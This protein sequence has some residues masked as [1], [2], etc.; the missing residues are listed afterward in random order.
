MHGSVRRIVSTGTLKK[1]KKK[2]PRQQKTGWA[3]QWCVVQP[4]TLQ[5]IILLGGLL[6]LWGDRGELKAVEILQGF[7]RNLA[8]SN[9]DHITHLNVSA[10]FTDENSKSPRHSWCFWE[11]LDHRLSYLFFVMVDSAELKRYKS[12]SSTDTVYCD[13][14]DFY[15]LAVRSAGENDRQR[16]PEQSTC[17]RCFDSCL[18]IG[19]YWC[20]QNWETA[21]LLTAGVNAEA[22]IQIAAHVCTRQAWADEVC[23]SRWWQTAPGWRWPEFCCENIRKSSLPAH[24]QRGSVTWQRAEG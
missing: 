16:K 24:T 21:G 6:R 7:S 3:A 23:L 12:G 5:V 20:G 11:I 19:L 4:W 14:T 8:I 13:H 17:V 10:A 2:H 22:I 1:K 9:L 15:L 18:Y